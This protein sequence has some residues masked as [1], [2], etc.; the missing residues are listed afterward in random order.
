MCF[1]VGVQ[2]YIIIINECSSVN[3]LIL[4]NNES[5]LAFIQG[6]SFCI[7]RQIE[8]FK[9]LK[10]WFS[11]IYSDLHSKLLTKAGWND[12]FSIVQF[13]SIFLWRSFRQFIILCHTQITTIWWTVFLFLIHCNIWFTHV[14]FNTLWKPISWHF[15]KVNIRCYSLGYLIFDFNTFYFLNGMH[16]IEMYK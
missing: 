14:K 13:L 1:K 12:K 10:S 11:S 9:I 16:L 5:C 4:E 7:F 3:I 2:G 6:S 15:Q 8:Y